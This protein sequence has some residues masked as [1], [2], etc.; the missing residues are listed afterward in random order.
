MIGA[1]ARLRP[2]PI[3]LGIGAIA[4]VRVSV[5]ERSRR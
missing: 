5:I 3:D 4:T 2:G 1:L